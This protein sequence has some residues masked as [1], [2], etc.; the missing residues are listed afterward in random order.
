MTHQGT[1]RGPAVSESGNVVIPRCAVKGRL[2]SSFHKLALLFI[3]LHEQVFSRN[4]GQFV[5]VSQRSAVAWSSSFST[6]FFSSLGAEPSKRLRLVGVAPVKQHL[7]SQRPL[8]QFLPSRPFFFFF[9]LRF[10]STRLPISGGKPSFTE[11]AVT[12]APYRV[13]SPFPVTFELEISSHC[14][15]AFG[16]F[17]NS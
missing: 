15:S 7:P 12:P 13:A 4:E 16:T 8:L 9:V 10:F 2:E 1:A 14:F 11:G 17:V 6:P 5:R 3:K